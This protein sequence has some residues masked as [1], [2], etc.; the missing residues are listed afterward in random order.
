MVFLTLNVASRSGSLMRAQD[1]WVERQLDERVGVALTD[2]L[3][4]V[5]FGERLG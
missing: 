2:G 4:G 3:V 1:A 5:C